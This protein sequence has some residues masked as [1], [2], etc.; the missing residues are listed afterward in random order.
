ERR[1]E[2]SR[3]DEELARSHEA[4]PRERPTAR[5]LE[6][7]RRVARE[8]RRAGAVQLEVQPARLLEVVR[9]DLQHLVTGALPQPPCEALVQLGA[10][11]LGEARVGDL[12]DQ[13]V[14]EPVRTLA[15]DRRPPLL[16]QELAQEEV[17]DEGLDVLELR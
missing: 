4:L 11:R 14:L 9:A 3:L 15:G 17:V 6:R 1:L 10:R 12:A 7:R 8:R 2:L 16:E 5:G 13:D